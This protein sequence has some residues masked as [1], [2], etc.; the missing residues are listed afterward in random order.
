MDYFSSVITKAQAAVDQ[1]L[2]IDEALANEAIEASKTEGDVLS[3]IAGK[4]G[5]AKL[6][7]T[8][9]KIAEETTK[10]LAETSKK[11]VE[12]VKEGVHASPG[13]L[14]LSGSWGEGKKGGAPRESNVPKP[15]DFFF[16]S[17][18]KGRREGADFDDFDFPA[19][20]RP[21]SRKHGA[22][23]AAGASA[24]ATSADHRCSP[25]NSP[26]ETK[27]DGGGQAAGADD[28]WEDAA[29]TP[30]PVDG[31]Q[32]GWGDEIELPME[33]APGDPTTA[34]EKEGKGHAEEGKGSDHD[35]A[36]SAASSGPGS[37][38]VPAHES[39]ATQQSCSA[40]DSTAAG[41]HSGSPAGVPKD[42]H[43]EGESEPAESVAVAAGHGDGGADA[44]ADGNGG[45]G[46]SGEMGCVAEDTG[47]PAASAATGGGECAA[48]KDKEASLGAA[49][50]RLTR[51]TGSD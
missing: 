46:D 20:A 17:P 9:K 45:N 26:D 11:V 3:V 16:V 31:A 23:S 1:T 49:M 30:S 24:A 39:A 25:A 43:P 18:G 28:R 22:D 40:D 15:D 34:P 44:D 10:K 13:G 32:H 7:E 47:V 21:L 36:A 48:C 6:S 14:S 38:V 51:M 41:G 5:A 8:T 29:W 33:I 50:T 27:V 12:H 42:A 4:E 35:V 2:G 19:P 37:G